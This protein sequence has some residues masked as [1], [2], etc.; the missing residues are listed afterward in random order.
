MASATVLFREVAIS[1]NS[2]NASMVL[3]LLLV[4]INAIDVTRCWGYV[5]WSIGPLVHG[6]I[7]AFVHWTIGPL[8]H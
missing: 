8:V 2:L 6:T 1:L 7:G 5:L 3:L 4:G